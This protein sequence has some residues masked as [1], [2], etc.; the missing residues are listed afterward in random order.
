MRSYREIAEGLAE[1]LDLLLKATLDSATDDGQALDASETA[2]REKALTAIAEMHD[3]RQA[4]DGAGQAADSQRPGVVAKTIADDLNAQG[5]TTA[6][7]RTGSDTFPQDVVE[8]DGGDSYLLVADHLP[9]L[10]VNHMEVEIRD[11]RARAAE[12]E[13]AIAGT[14]AAADKACAENFFLVRRD[15][16]ALLDAVYSSAD[17]AADAVRRDIG[18]LPR[19]PADAKAAVYDILRARIERTMTATP[20]VEVSYAVE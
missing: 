3:R 8:L 14:L 11:L 16:L 4:D 20:H 12:L 5:W 18:N 19:V 6:C 13:K 10:S 1:A 17:A 9:K 7:A 2:L 15:G